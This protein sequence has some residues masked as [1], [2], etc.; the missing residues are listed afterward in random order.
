MVSTIEEV[1]TIDERP[2]NP[3]RL[4]VVGV[5]R[6]GRRRYD[7][8]E[9]AAPDGRDRQR[10]AAYRGEGDGVAACAVETC[11]PPLRADRAA[12]ADAGTAPAG[13]HRHAIHARAL[14]GS[15]PWA[16]RSRR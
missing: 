9:P 5:L 16:A 12:H 3:L 13:Q 15:G 6:N 11:M 2:S 8:P 14:A 7:L 4:K 10:A 1:D